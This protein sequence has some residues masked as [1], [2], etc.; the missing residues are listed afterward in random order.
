M[1]PEHLRSLGF[2]RNQPEDRESLSRTRKPGH[3][4]GWQGTE[5]NHTHSAIH[6]LIK[7]E[8]QT[9][10]LERYGSSSSTPP[11]RQRFILMEHGQQEVQPGIPL[12]RTWSKLPED[13]SQRD[14]LQRPYGNH[15]RLESNQAVQTPGGEGKQDKGESSHYP[16]YRRTADPES[17]YTG[18]LRLT[19][20][21]PNKLSSSFTPFRNQ[22]ISVQESLFLTIPGGFQ[23]RTRIQGQ[24]QDHLNPEEERVRPND[25]EAVGFGERSAQEPEVVVNN[26]RIS[27]LIN[28]NITPTQTEHNVVTP[29]SNLKSDSLWLQM[30]Q[31]A[32]KTQKQFAELQASHERMKTLT[33]SMDKIGK[34]L[35]EGHA[36]LRKASEETN[37]RLNLVFEE[38]HHSKKDRDCLNQDIKKLFNVYHNMKPQPQGHVMYNP[39]HQD[40]IKPYAMLINKARSPSQYQ[41]GDNM[42][43]SP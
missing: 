14:R 23:E 2:Q 21:R 37:K 31:F 25:P 5:V 4:G 1:S 34:T 15:L 18:S 8:P 28:R 12:G 33:A 42:S 19:R 20:S 10:G 29:N 35:Q 3:S 43:Y 17:S 32:E 22:Q 41:A 26:S 7:Q 9:R 24:K 40:D 36:Q 11:T 16:S 38:Q 30:S 27:I 13:L 6:F 39:Y